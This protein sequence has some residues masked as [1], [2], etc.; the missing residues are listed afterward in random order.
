MIAQSYVKR[1]IILNFPSGTED[2]SLQ[3]HKNVNVQIEQIKT[4]ANLAKTSAI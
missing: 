3:T 1:I 2:A 4:S